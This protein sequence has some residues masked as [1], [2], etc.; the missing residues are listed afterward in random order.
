MQSWSLHG[1]QQFFFLCFFRQIGLNLNTRIH[2]SFRS[3]SS[4]VCDTLHTLQRHAL[5]AGLCHW[6]SRGQHVY[7][8]KAAAQTAD[9]SGTF[10]CQSGASPILS[11]RSHAKA[12]PGG[13]G[14]AAFAIH[15]TC[16]VR[17]TVSFAYKPEAFITEQ[18][19]NN[20]RLRAIQ[21][22]KLSATVQH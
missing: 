7:K 15:V 22:D 17:A 3:I 2:S 11:A 13:E 19:S 6:V 12:L 18:L 9:Q 8:S 16:C 4:N 5:P 21:V 20:P 10:F 14:N 1:L